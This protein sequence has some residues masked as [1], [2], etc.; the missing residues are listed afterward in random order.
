M[1][2]PGCSVL[3]LPIISHPPY[4]KS[5]IPSSYL[6]SQ[7]CRGATERNPKNHLCCRLNQ[8]SFFSLP[9]QG[10]CFNPW[11][12]W[13]PS[14]KSTLVYLCLYELGSTK[15]TAILLEAVQGMLCKGRWLL[16]SIFSIT[17]L[18]ILLLLFAAKAHC[19]LLLTLCLSTYLTSCQR[20]YSS[21]SS[22]AGITARSFSFPGEGPCAWPVAS[23]SWFVLNT[24]VFIKHTCMTQKGIFILTAETG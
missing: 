23:V 1:C 7:R 2:S 20:C 4:A 21:Q 3:S 9:S 17:Q 24:R 10:E 6:F 19:W 18:R 13:W 12:S 11:P 15:L 5:L 22:P 14:T 8:P 16:C